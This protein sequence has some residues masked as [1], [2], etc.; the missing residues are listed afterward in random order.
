MKV[1]CILVPHFAVQVERLRRPELEGRAL[2][3]V[4]EHGSRRT[5]LDRSG[6]AR[7]VYRGMALYQ[8]LARM[9]S[10]LLLRA[11]M[12]YYRACFERMLDALEQRSPLVEGA[13]PGLAYLGLDGLEGLYGG[14]DRLL[15]ALLA[16]VP[17][18]LEARIGVGPAKFPSY[19]AALSSR[20]GRVARV[21]DAVKGFLSPF[22]VGILPVSGEMKNRLRRFGLGTLGQV[23]S[24]PLG[25]VQA[26]FG[27]EGRWAWELASGIDPRPVIPRKATEVI[28]E[29]CSFP[30]PAV[31]LAAVLAGLEALVGRA[32]SRL[33]GRSARVATLRGRAFQGSLWERRV[34]FKE[35]LGDRSRALFALRSALER[36]SFPGPLEDLQLTLAGLTGESGRQGSFFAEVRQWEQLDESLRQLE[37]RLGRKPPLYQVREMEP[38]SRIP[39]RRRALVP[40]VP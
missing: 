4:E 8:A 30:S 36:A 33:R 38:W 6:Q 19:V 32:F 1:A 14:E 25:A 12:P 27:P 18:G 9:E 20:P 31:S 40:F 29:S 22:P 16:A 13:E 37:A 39:E 11:D 3:V 23:A 26:Q 21:P 17:S 34:A 24:L 35:P 15:A 7:G 10:P 28:E 5:V 2:L